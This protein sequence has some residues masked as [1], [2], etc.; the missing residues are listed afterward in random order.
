VIEAWRID[1]NHV[2]PH[3]SLGQRTP[4]EALREARSTQDSHSEYSSFWG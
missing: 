1:Y 4:I 3:R 2:R